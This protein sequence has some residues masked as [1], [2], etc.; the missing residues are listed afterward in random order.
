MRSTEN[1]FRRLVEC[2]RASRG[3]LET[4]QVLRD[5]GLIGAGPFLGHAGLR[6]TIPEQSG[7]TPVISRILVYSAN[8]D[9]APAERRRRGARRKVASGARRK[10]SACAP[11]SSSSMVRIWMRG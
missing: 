8:L 4:T 11:A 7:I 2:A 1:L 3:D 9:C 6:E 10:Y 5:D